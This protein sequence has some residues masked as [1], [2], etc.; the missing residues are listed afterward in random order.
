MTEMLI[1]H[2]FSPKNVKKIQSLPGLCLRTLSKIIMSSIKAQPPGENDFLCLCFMCFD[3]SFFRRNRAFRRCVFLYSLREK[4]LLS[5]TYITAFLHYML[6]L[7]CVIKRGWGAQ[8]TKEE[9]RMLWMGSD[10]R[11]RR[12]QN[13]FCN[14]LFYTYLFISLLNALLLHSPL[15]E[16]G[17]LITEWRSLDLLWSNIRKAESRGPRRTKDT[18]L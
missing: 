13:P 12:S 17:M 1:W 18:Q 11:D 10:S 6:Q 9:R 4:D 5:D 14:V 7:T 2:P 15:R 3:K 8:E 16:L